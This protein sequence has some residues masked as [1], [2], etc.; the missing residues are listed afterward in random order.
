MELPVQI[1]PG[2]ETKRY[3]RLMRIIANAG[4]FI[5]SQ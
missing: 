5:G 3:K 4:D 1:L 2:L